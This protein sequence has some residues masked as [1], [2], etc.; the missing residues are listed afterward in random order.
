MWPHAAP[1]WGVI[2]DG[3]HASLGGEFGVGIVVIVVK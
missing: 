3:T 2:G 1:K